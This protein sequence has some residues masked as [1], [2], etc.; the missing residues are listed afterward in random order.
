MLTLFHRF[1]LLA[2]L[3][4]DSAAFIRIN[5]VGYLPDGLK[6]AV[7]CALE[8]VELQRFTVE[9]EQGRIVFGP[10]VAKRSGAFGPCTETWRLDFS[11]LRTTGRYRVRAGAYS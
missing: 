11:A 9:T 5:Q 2:T 1:L 3:Q 4:Q 10:S 8:A 7:V 6:T